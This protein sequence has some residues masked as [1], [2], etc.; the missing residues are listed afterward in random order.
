MSAEQQFLKQLFA[1]RF[2]VRNPDM[3][4][5]RIRH[6]I[7]AA[8]VLS[9]EPDRGD[10]TGGGAV[11]VTVILGEDAA[12]PAVFLDP[13]RRE[14]GA[15]PETPGGRFR[16]IGRDGGVYVGLRGEVTEGVTWRGGAAWRFAYDGHL[17]VLQ[18]RAYY[19]VELPPKPESICELTL[20]DG[21]VLKAR[22]ADISLGGLGGRL[23]RPP[24]SDDE[25]PSAGV[26]LDAIRFTLPGSREI[27]CKGR[28]VSLR[29]T[30]REQGGHYIVGVQFTRLGLGQEQTISTF[31]RQREREI[32]RRERGF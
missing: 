10:D 21:A 30:R 17:W 23:V 29:R 2:R 14:D 31:I 7:D 19:R 27:R 1:E 3:A 26:T 20:P 8:R 24:D 5:V 11:H 6:L 12:G 28:L 16:L 25:L 13:F 15:I 9:V 4:R 32:R 18:R 22:M